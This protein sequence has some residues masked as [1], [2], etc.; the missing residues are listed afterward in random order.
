MSQLPSPHE[1]IKEFPLSLKQKEFIAQARKETVN[2][3]NGSNHRLLFIIGPCSIHHLAAAKEYANRLKQL[4]AT[5]SDQFVII[6]RTYF[7]KARTNT[8]WKGMLYDPH[9]TGSADIAKGIAL[10]R[11]F[12]LEMANMQIPTAME[13]LDPSTP[14]YLADL[15]TWGSIGARTVTSQI[16]RQMASGLDMPIAFKNSIEGNTCVAIQ[17]IS[18]AKAAHSFLGINPKGHI[19]QIQTKGNPYGHIALRGGENK[20][21]YDPQS[22]EEITHALK[23]ADIH[24]R[25][26][27]DCSH[28]NCRGNYRN[29][30]F[31][32]NSIVEQSMEN[33]C[34]IAGIILESYL[35]ADKQDFSPGIVPKKNKSITDPCIG[36]E[37]TKALILQAYE[38]KHSLKPCP[39]TS[40][41]SLTH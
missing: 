32:F 39:N 34:R 18:S 41:L 14:L 36:W 27:V 30:E 3:L 29:Q 16:H 13:F 1:I 12:L 10:S 17:A 2:I 26:L 25:I 8:G 35:E 4:I 9:L 33:H 21:N 6:M 37:K 5:V 22:I 28:D 11:K 23:Q 31:V 38:K 20:T 24:T 40:L 7:E 15:V 19:S